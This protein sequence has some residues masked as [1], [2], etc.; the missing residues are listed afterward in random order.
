MNVVNK[1]KTIILD[2][3]NAKSPQ[4][5][6]INALDMFVRGNTESFIDVTIAT[7]VISKRI[8][9]WKVLDMET[10]TVHKYIGFEIQGLRSGKDIDIDLEP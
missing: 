9:N 5:E 3:I 8:I 2:D 7:K 6:W 1:T 4:F 10:L